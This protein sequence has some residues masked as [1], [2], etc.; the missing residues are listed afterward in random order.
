MQSAFTNQYFYSLEGDA[1]LDG[2]F[3]IFISCKT[4]LMLVKNEKE[5]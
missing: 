2:K 3:S 4:L 5:A 1:I